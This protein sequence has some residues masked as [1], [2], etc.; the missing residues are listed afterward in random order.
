MTKSTKFLLSI[1][2]LF[3][4]L[5]L[6]IFWPIF[7]GKVNLNGNLL[8]SFYVLYG[9]NLPYKNIVG[10]DQLRLYFPNYSLVIEEIKNFNLPQWN[11]YIFAGNLNLASLQSAVFYPLNV[12][13]LIL[14]HVEFWHLLR[15]SPSI[16]GSFFTFLFLRNL[17]ISKLAALFGSIIFGFSPFI[18]TWGEEQVNTP[19]TI[20]W[21]PLILF[22][23]DKLV[24]SRPKPSFF[25]EAYF[26]LIAISIAFS[27]F[28]GFIQTTIYLVIF[29][30][31]YAVFRV[32]IGKKNIWAFCKIL[33]AFLVGIALSAIQLVP[34]AQLYFDSARSTVNL[35]EVLFNFLLPI[36]SILTLFAPDLF[37]NP[38]T[39][40][41]FRRG[42]ATYYEG[43]MFIGVPTIIFAFYIIFEKRKEKLVQFLAIA[44][45]L[46]L[47]FTLALPTSKFFISLPIP[48]LST[49]ITNRL[50]FIP[51]FSL[52]VLASLGIDYWIS[53]KDK[54]IF[55]YILA[56]ATIYTFIILYLL[57]VKFLRFPYF[58][59]GV[60]STTETL[61]ISFRNLA[62]P[63]LVFGVTSFSILI[64]TFKILKVSRSKVALLVIFITYLHFF[65]FAQKYFSFSDRK[66]VFPEL[67][68]LNFIK[69]NQG[70]YRSWGVGKAY[71][72]N[73]FATQYRI[74]WPEGYNSLNIRSYAEFTYLMQGAKLDDFVFRADAGLGHGK[75]E[76]LIPDPNRRKLIDLVGVKYVIASTNGSQIME[77]N[78]FRKVF[79]SSQDDL[80]FAVFENLEVMPRAFLA[81][82][83]EGPPQVASFG[84]NDKQIKEERRKLIPQ[85]LLSDSF[86]FR[87]VLIL[88][89][90]SPI[91]A[92]FGEGNAEI[93]SYKPQEV[94][95]KTKS[96]RP[97][98]LFLS[99]NYYPG[100]KAT[101]DGD[102]TEILRA[103]YTFR[104]VP[105]TAGDHEVR[106]YYDSEVFKVGAAISILS[107]LGL[108]FLTLRRNRRAG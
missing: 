94:I 61:R 11:P 37:G 42:L 1:L 103:N 30:L 82:N 60:F 49:S 101:V 5:T 71:F 99:D 102:E 23:I 10:L 74:F 18:I 87:N 40:N 106:F 68:V 47:F 53:T 45:L 105:L 78:N 43:I 93:L 63:I 36:E 77:A 92:Q 58:H 80:G 79:T 88:E 108:G 21:L 75:T 104:A 100:W 44:G 66:N 16:L 57:G 65:L 9:E 39:W 98:L 12:F 64:V 8:V 15:I 25:N 96:N 97:K 67:S 3:I 19:H 24:Q 76:E 83:Y 90:P 31:F 33:A 91:S 89:E 13:S 54:K 28:A 17:R 70:V 62:L 95:I 73:N 52:A 56:V 26:S 20:I 4:F 22:C 84:K 2:I 46:A 14:P 107:F 41:F 55:K 85:K 7:F 50:L 32:G 69:E 59:S 6:A 29:S 72:E 35:K 48:F 27:V 34:T 86:D 81:S 38:V 51:T